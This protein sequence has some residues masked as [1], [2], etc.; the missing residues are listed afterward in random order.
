MKKTR[1]CFFDLCLT[2]FMCVGSLPIAL[3]YAIMSKKMGFLGF[4]GIWALT[5]FGSIA[6]AVVLPFAMVGS[7]SLS[8]LTA[9]VGGVAFLVETICCLR[10]NSTLQTQQQPVMQIPHDVKI[11]REHEYKQ[12]E[13]TYSNALSQI[14]KAKDQ[15]EISK[16]KLAL[17][18]AQKDA[19][20]AKKTALPS[21]PPSYSYAANPPTYE[22]ALLQPSLLQELYNN[23]F[24]WEPTQLEELNARWARFISTPGKAVL[25]NHMLRGPLTKEQIE[26]MQQ[27]LVD[28]DLMVSRLFNTAMMDV[29]SGVV[30]SVMRIPVLLYGNVYDLYTLDSLPED[31]KGYRTEP[32]S[33]ARFRKE[34]VV[35]YN[36]LAEAISFLLHDI[37]KEAQGTGI[38]DKDASKITSKRPWGLQ[39]IQ[40]PETRMLEAFYNT[41]PPRHKK[42][43]NIMCRDAMTGDILVD[44]V[45]LPD[46]HT[47]NQKTI[48]AI[49]GPVPHQGI[50]WQC[51][52]N[53]D[54]IFSTFE[55]QKC[56]PISHVLAVLK[57]EVSWNVAAQ[58]RQAS[59]S[60]DGPR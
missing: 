58:Q 60:N 34:N 50:S 32:R 38:T 49:C 1:E 8:I 44:P 23:Y 53:P 36:T 21:A 43:F 39:N 40:T 41:L 20:E 5:F 7:F 27:Q 57:H 56:H 11:K 55:V 26:I 52:K 3:L 51:P 59:F 48:D 33:G 9:A 29:D 31:E 16:L 15:D 37:A 42:L 17:V 4:L 13:A 28:K 30:Q 12:S 47:Y 25:P 14:Q 22:Q 18:Q 2:P 19:A 35:P 6:A 45:T 10:R 54:I 46:G 24:R